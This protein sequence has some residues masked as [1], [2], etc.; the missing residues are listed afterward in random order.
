MNVDEELQLK[1]KLMVYLHY[2]SDESLS[3]S[4]IVFDYLCR[5]LALAFVLERV[6]RREAQVGSALARQAASRHSE[7]LPEQPHRHYHITTTIIISSSSSIRS[8]SRSR[9]VAMRGQQSGHEGQDAAHRLPA[10]VGQGV[11]PRSRH[12]RALQGHSVGE[13]R[14]RA[15][16]QAIRLHSSATLHQSRPLD[17]ERAR[18]RG[19]LGQ[20]HCRAEP[21]PARQHLRQ[22]R[23]H[24]WRVSRLLKRYFFFRYNTRFLTTPL[25]LTYIYVFWGVFANFNS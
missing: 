17:T 11:A 13:Q 10:P 4:S 2:I 16:G 14:W 1:H 25:F 24:H 21:A 22:Q 9:I 7:G 12:G 8:R 6:D 5:V 19:L 18:S 3:L 20:L 15:T 23:V